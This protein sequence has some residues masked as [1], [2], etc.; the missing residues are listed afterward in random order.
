MYPSKYETYESFNVY[1]IYIYIYIIVS[2]SM[3]KVMTF[4]IIF[5]EYHS[6]AVCMLEYLEMKLRKFDHTFFFKLLFPIN[7][8]Q[9]HQISYDRHNCKSSG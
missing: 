7:I 3:Q 1:F 8:F 2:K 6:K 5:C 4:M 9:L